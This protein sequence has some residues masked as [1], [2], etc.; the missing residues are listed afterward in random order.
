MSLPFSFY[1]LEVRK[2]LNLC[3]IS[4]SYLLQNFATE[5]CFCEDRLSKQNEICISLPT[6]IFTQRTFLSTVSDIH[7]LVIFCSFLNFMKQETPS[8]RP[9]Y[10]PQVTNSTPFSHKQTPLNHQSFVM[11]G[12]NC[13]AFPFYTSVEL[14]RKF[15]TRK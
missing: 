9:N 11:T 13:D 4:F 1:T 10:K 7:Y 3:W 2:L 14:T 8:Q 5:I 15:L 12:W 6:V